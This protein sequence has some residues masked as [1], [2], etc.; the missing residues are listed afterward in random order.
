M[1]VADAGRFKY[2]HGLVWDSVAD[3]G[4][5]YARDIHLS[6]LKLTEFE[7]WAPH[8]RK[9]GVYQRAIT[10]EVGWRYEEE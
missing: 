9:I 7:V 10:C 6:G 3:M 5:P 1:S 8:P 4:V 2:A